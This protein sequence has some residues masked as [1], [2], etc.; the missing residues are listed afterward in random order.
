[1][2]AGL[3]NKITGSSHYDGLDIFVEALV[4]GFAVAPSWQSGILALGLALAFLMGQSLRGKAFV[5]AIILGIV[6]H[7]CFII[8]YEVHHA[9][10]MLGV[11]CAAPFIIVQRVVARRRGKR[12]A[13]VELP[14]AAALG[15]PAASLMISGGKPLGL[16]FS[17]WGVIAV[18]AVILA[19][20]KNVAEARMAEARARAGAV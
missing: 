19:I 17:V 5:P 13:W 3:L 1:M 9:P 11:L 14:G 10:F 2:G 18:Q 16:A 20:Y 7:A 12:L 6:A 15:V 8:S 4:I